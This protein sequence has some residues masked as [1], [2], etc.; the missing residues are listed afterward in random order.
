VRGRLHDCTTDIS[1]WCPSVGLNSTRTRRSL[2]GLIISALALNIVLGMTFLG[3]NSLSVLMC[4][5][6]VHPSINQSI[7]LALHKLVNIEQTSRRCHAVSNSC[8]RVAASYTRPRAQHMTQ[9]SAKMTSS[10]SC[11]NKLS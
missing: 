10:S 5:K 9:H 8:S 7:N 6:A 1:T 11:F 2:L 4:R 3:T